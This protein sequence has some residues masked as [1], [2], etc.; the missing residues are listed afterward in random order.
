MGSVTDC[1]LPQL[2]FPPS[3]SLCLNFLQNRLGLACPCHI[4]LPGAPGPCPGSP[5]LLM[6][7]FLAP[8]AESSRREAVMSSQVAVQLYSSLLGC[9]GS[10][11]ELAR[12]QG[13]NGRSVFFFFWPNWRRNCKHKYQPGVKTKVFKVDGN[14]R[15]TCVTLPPYVEEPLVSGLFP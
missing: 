7:Q 14:N 10:W 8:L 6:A 9:R 13:K 11:T 5:G 4:P 12:T 15:K 3:S 2:I 1:Y